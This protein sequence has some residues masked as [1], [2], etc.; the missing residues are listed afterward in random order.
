MGERAGVRWRSGF[1][2]RS[3][4]ILLNVVRIRRHKLLFFSVYNLNQA[5][6][7]LYRAP[8]FEQTSISIIS[9]L[10]IP[11]SD[12]FN[13]L[14]CQ[15]C[16][17]YFVFLDFLRQTMVKTVEFNSEFCLHAIKI[18]RVIPFGM[19]PTEFE[20]RKLTTSQCTP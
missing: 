15:F 3:V 9:P 5:G 11:K 8:Y 19:L 17:A 1:R 13:V 12:N 4:L 18:E 6:S 16:R 10:M 2:G 20:T 7:P 14:F